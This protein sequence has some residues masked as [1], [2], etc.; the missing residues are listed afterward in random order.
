MSTGT[1]VFQCAGVEV[2]AHQHQDAFPFF[3]RFLRDNLFDRVIEIGTAAGGFAWWLCH[4]AKLPLTTYDIKDMPLH[5]SLREAGVNVVH[6][7]VFSDQHRKDMQDSL[8]ACGRVLLL[9]DGGNKV[10]EFNEFAEF[11][12][13]D[14]VIMAHDYSADRESYESRTCAKWPWWEI[15][16]E[17]VEQTAASQGLVI[18]DASSEEALWLSMRKS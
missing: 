4:N 12:K 17:D 14:D 3:E 2:V 7:D 10:R 9:C 6:G 18:A 5:A 15:R 1:C 8:R 13:R 16:W 11:L